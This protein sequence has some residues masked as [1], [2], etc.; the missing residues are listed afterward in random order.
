M[1]QS[2]RDITPGISRQIKLVMTDVDGTLTP[3]GDSLSREFRRLLKN[4]QD[5]GLMIGLVSGRHLS[6]LEAMAVDLD[7]NGPI[8]AENGAVAKTR[9]GADLVKLNY[10]QETAIKDLQKLKDLF[11]GLSR[12]GRIIRTARLIWFSGHREYRSKI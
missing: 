12:K 9:A 7:L 11:P 3:G 5:S 10:S 4:L 1:S 6:N 2:Y 8:I